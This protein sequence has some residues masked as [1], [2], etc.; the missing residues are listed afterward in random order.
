MLRLWLPPKVWFQ[1]SQSTITG[2]WSVRKVQ[3]A[4]ALSWLAHIMRWVLMTPLGWPVEPE[5][6]SILATVSG[7]TCPNARSTAGVGRTS[8]SAETGVSRQPASVPLL[9]TISS[10]VAPIVSSALA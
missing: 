6:K 3:A 1:G 5:V 10:R 9:A 4:A 7:P 2:G 8:V